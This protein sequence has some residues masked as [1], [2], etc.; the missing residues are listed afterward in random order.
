MKTINVKKKSNSKIV[1]F[2]DELAILS[3]KYNIVLETT[4][5]MFMTDDGGDIGSVKYDYNLNKYIYY[6][7]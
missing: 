6:K 3:Q 4:D 2:L 5:D 7:E 1:K